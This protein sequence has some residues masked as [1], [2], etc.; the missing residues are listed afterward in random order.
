VDLSWL[1]HPDTQLLPIA[2]WS[3]PVY[4]RRLHSGLDEVYGPGAMAS[5]ASAVHA[6]GPYSLA[7]AMMHQQHAAHAA[8]AAGAYAH[9][10]AAV[11]ALLPHVVGPPEMG[12]A[13]SQAVVPAAGHGHGHGHGH[14]L[15]S[16]SAHPSAG[17]YCPDAAAVAAA[18]MQHIAMQHHGGPVPTSMGALSA[19]HLPGVGVSAA[20]MNATTSGGSGSGSGGS[21]GGG[22]SGSGSGSGHGHT[23]GNHN[24]GGGNA[25]GNG[26]GAAL[27]AQQLPQYSLHTTGTTSTCPGVPLHVAAVVETHAHPQQTHPCPP[28]PTLT[29]DQHQ[30]HQ[31]QQQQPALSLPI[32]A[33]QQPLAITGGPAC[34]THADQRPGVMHP[35]HDTHNP[36]GAA[37][38]DHKSSGFVHHHPLSSYGFVGDSAGTGMLHRQGSS[39]DNAQGAA[40]GCS[41]PRDNGGVTVAAVDDNDAAARGP[42][43]G[44]GVQALP[45][46]HDS[47]KASPGA[48]GSNGSSDSNMEDAV[49][50]LQ[51]LRQCDDGGAGTAGGA[52]A[53]G[54]AAADGGAGAGAGAGAGGA[55]SGGKVGRSATRQDTDEAQ[56]DQQQPSTLCVVGGTAAI[57]VQQ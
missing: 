3:A 21:G 51:A 17:E 18:A 16:H 32:G 35:D 48:A 39:S 50:G 19:P 15:Y 24:P 5:A 44:T 54:G 49:A 41:T 22:G 7:A 28:K 11:A 29:H 2:L 31:Q 38:V 20:L 12:P 23:H 25:R 26:S 40:G 27:S 8:A 36:T 10:H 56:R 30:H 6:A 13:A 47:S 43:G 55:G 9:A 53:V 33:M 1:V 57:A 52:A 34:S 45:L 42:A 37:V 14:G 4:S 46:H